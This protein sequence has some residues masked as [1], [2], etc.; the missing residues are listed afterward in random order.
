MFISWGMQTATLGLPPFRNSGAAPV[1]PYETDRLRSEYLLFHYGSPEEVL[2]Y[3]FGPREALDYAVRCVLECVDLRLAVGGRALDLGCA[4]G[5]SAFELSRECA[6]VVGVDFSQSFVDAA[7]TIRVCG[8]LGYE[9]VDEGHWRTSLEARLPEGAKPERVRFERGDAMAL[10]EGL[11]VFDV[12]LMANLIDRL[13]DP[14]RCL[15]GLRE[16]VKPGGQ[17]VITS[18]Y[19]WMAEYT[20]EEAWLGGRESCGKRCGTLDGLRE[21]LGGAFECVGTKD[22][23]FLI[24]EHARKFQWSVA[25][26]SLWRRRVS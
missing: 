25:E 1:N 14:R 18:P 4:V 24:R 17:L 12:V 8:K 19:T 13:S 20:P 23:P 5:R 22:L 9:R 21:V 26:A 6:E 10:R 11:G 15:E 16:R 2:P 7:E 3:P